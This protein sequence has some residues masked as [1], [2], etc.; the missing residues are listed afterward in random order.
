[1]K[2][3]LVTGATSGLGRNA[4][5]YLLKT[6]IPVRATGR[7]AAVGAELAAAGAQ[8]VALDLATAGAPELLE[9][10]SGCD[11]VWHCAALSSPWGSLADFEAANVTATIELAK[12]ALV[13][14]ATRFVHVSTPALYFD[15][16][17]RLGI[18]EDF[19]PKRYVNH[20]AATKARAEAELREL[21]N[22]HGTL[23]TT[24]LRPRAIFGPHDRVLLPRLLRLVAEREGSLVLPRA[25]KTVLDLTYVDNV[26][27]AMHFA[28]VS[29]RHES[30]EAFNVTNGEPVEIGATLRELFHHLKRPLTL[31]GAPAPLLALAGQ[32][33]ELL[34][35]LTGK[36]PAVTRYSLGALTY[37]MTLDIRKAGQQLCYAPVVPMETAL[38]RTA[39]WL[40]SNP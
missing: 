31:R 6:G 39:A 21:T 2:R 33:A 10:V 32:G 12:A 19:V 14:R 11:T 13:A 17:H 35:H 4:V 20:Y 7:N 29:H 22:R 15:F 40:K 9:L 16:K 34:G 38:Q 5:E 36:E 28:S 27:R 25:G 23:H 24:I 37:D 30:G 1:M 3:V 8:F 18:R 26:V